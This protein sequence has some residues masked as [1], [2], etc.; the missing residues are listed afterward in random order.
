MNF[1][2]LRSVFLSIPVL[3]SLASLTGAEANSDIE[4]QEVIRCEN[5]KNITPE[6]PNATLRVFTSVKGNKSTTILLDSMPVSEPSKSLLLM[7]VKFG[8]KV[9]FPNFDINLNITHPKVQIVGTLS[10]LA[11]GNGGPNTPH[12]NDIVLTINGT[13]TPCKLV[14]YFDSG[15]E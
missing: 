13:A 4:T 5:V 14:N 7:K 8:R 15:L 2:T 11:T 1:N 9:I 12:K 6:I 3:F 10:G